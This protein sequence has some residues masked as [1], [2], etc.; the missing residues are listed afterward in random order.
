MSEELKPCTAWGS[1]QLVKRETGAEPHTNRLPHIECYVCGLGSPHCSTIEEAVDAW[2]ALPCVLEWTS[3]PPKVPG[4]YWFRNVS[5]PTM[6][7]IKRVPMERRPHP[8]D[9]WAGPIPEP[10]ESK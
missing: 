1:H 10:R 7:Y 5:K 2:N 6:L 3:E 8:A 4:W 9:E